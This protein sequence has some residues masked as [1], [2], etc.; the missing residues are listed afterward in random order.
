MAGNEF[1]SWRSCRDADFK[2][3]RYPGR[4]AFILAFGLLDDACLSF[5]G[6]NFHLRFH[7]SNCYLFNGMAAVFSRSK[8]PEQQIIVSASVALYAAD[9]SVFCS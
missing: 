3:R 1:S 9:C 4:N 6:T 8:T 2:P 5:F 7:F